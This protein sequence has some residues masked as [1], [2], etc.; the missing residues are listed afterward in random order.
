MYN[1]ATKADVKSTT[2]FDTLSF[3]KKADLARLNSYV[4]KSDIDKLNNWP[5]I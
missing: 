4:D 5:T 3:A 2:G 1:Y